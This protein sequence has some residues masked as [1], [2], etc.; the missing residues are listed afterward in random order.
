MDK[1]R[2]EIEARRGIVRDE[3]GHIIRSK[4]WIENRIEYLSNRLEDLENRKKNI[5]VEIKER[6]QE[7]K[8]L[9]EQ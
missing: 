3:N 1:T 2:A 4:K 9:N 8:E 7:L 6:T 5:K